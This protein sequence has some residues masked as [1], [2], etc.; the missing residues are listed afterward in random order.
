MH[1]FSSYLSLKSENLTNE[2]KGMVVAIHLSKS[3]DTKLQTCALQMFWNTY[4]VETLVINL[5]TTSSK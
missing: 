2:L 3:T 1:L 5:H 4:P